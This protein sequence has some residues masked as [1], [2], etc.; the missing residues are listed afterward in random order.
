[1][2]SLLDKLRAVVRRDLLTALRYRRAYWALWIGIAL[3]LATFYYLARAVGPSFRPE[4]MDYYPFLLAGTAL[5]TFLMLGISAFVETVREAQ[6]SGTMEVLMNTNTSPAVTIGLS[7]VSQILGRLLHSVVYVGVGLLLFSVPLRSPNLLGCAL[8]LLLATLLVI[9][10]GIL[11]AALQVWTQR[12]QLLVWVIGAGGSLLAGA[13]F[14]VSALPGWLQAIAH[15][16]PLTYALS[17]FRIALLQQGD[18][19][20]LAL[21]LGVL[22]L[23]TVALLPLSLAIFSLVIRHARHDGSLAWY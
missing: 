11:G 2:S 4:N 21:P 7:A 16:I 9:A 14:P 22:A 6:A 19:A 13:M 3:E 10:I 23:F 20:A 5:Y 12:G 8:V 17:A 18:F 1:M 15:A